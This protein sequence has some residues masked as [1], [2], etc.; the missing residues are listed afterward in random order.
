M[1]TKLFWSSTHS[2]RFGTRLDGRPFEGRTG[3]L[4]GFACVRAEDDLRDRRVASF[5]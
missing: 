5:L 1:L 4:G 3:S 2:M